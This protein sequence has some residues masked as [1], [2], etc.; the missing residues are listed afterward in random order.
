MADLARSVASLR[1]S[2]EELVPDEVSSLLGAVPSGA[3]AR[4]DQVSTHGPVRLARHGMWTLQASETAPADLDAQV[5]ELL[6]LLTSDRRTWHQLAD[7]FAVDLF[8]GWFME[9]SNEGLWVSPHTLLTL[10]ERRI[11]LIL[12]IYGADNEVLG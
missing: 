5:N 1:V 3:Y 7:R 4:G 8:C 6:G 2:G 11:V 10:G 9:R 12:D